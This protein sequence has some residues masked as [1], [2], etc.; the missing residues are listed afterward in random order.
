MVNFFCE[1][2]IRGVIRGP[3]LYQEKIESVRERTVV[4][5]SSGGGVLLLRVVKY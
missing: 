2:V 5:F 4:F 3:Q 1:T